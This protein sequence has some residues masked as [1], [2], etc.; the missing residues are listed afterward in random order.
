MSSPSPRPCPRCQVVYSA[1][2]RFCPSDGATLDPHAADPLIGQTIAD[3][4]RVDALAGVGGY[5]QVY[6]GVQLG[7]DRPVAIKVM[8]AAQVQNPAALRRFETEARVLSQLRHPNTVRLIDFGRLADG[9]AWLAT[10]FLVGV[11]LQARLR[12]GPLSA[13][14]V[15]D[16]MTQ[17]TSALEET[18][19]AGV[20]HRDLKP[21]NLFLDTV[22]GREIVRVIDFGIAQQAEDVRLTAEG[23]TVGTSTYMSPEQIR[24]ERVDARSDLYSLGVVAYECLAGRAPFEGPNRVSVIMQ[25]LNDAPPPLAVDAEVASLIGWCLEKRADDRPP[26]AAAVLEA[27][28]DIRAGGPTSAA[29]SG[30]HRRWLVA[31][32]VL[33]IAVM[34]ALIGW[35]WEPATPRRAVKPVASAPP[36]DCAP[37]NAPTPIVK[38]VS[39]VASA[40]TVEAAPTVMSAASIASAPASRARRPRRVT[41]RAAPSTAPPSA[42]RPPE[43][44]F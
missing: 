6:R 12:D 21:G 15:L 27:I 16:L 33:G 9:R 29:P 13:S 32:L 44:L 8:P 20:V 11:T 41:P 42:P 2:V 26:D 19:A 40:P 28:E 14:E 3:R 10:P 37:S 35:T 23:Q 18:H 31:G 4:F 34:G 39:T 30:G 7:V 36:H 38:V 1:A 25:H 24:G 17:I 43:G 22:A 5:G